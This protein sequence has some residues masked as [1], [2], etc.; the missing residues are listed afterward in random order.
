M[1]IPLYGIPFASQIVYFYVSMYIIKSQIIKVLLSINTVMKPAL[2][3][4][5]SRM[6]DIRNAILSAKPHVK[7]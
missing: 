4:C 6:C 3:R 2:V 5:E 7:N 1:L